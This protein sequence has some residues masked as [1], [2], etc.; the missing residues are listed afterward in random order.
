[1]KVTSMGMLANTDDVSMIALVMVT[2]TRVHVRVLR[3][4][5]E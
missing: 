3:V 1:V 4:G 2:V 5:K